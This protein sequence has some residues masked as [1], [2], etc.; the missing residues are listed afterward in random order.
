M[1]KWA[2]SNESMNE[3][4]VCEFIN[5]KLEELSSLHFL[6]SALHL[7][8]SLISQLGMFTLRKDSGS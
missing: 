7:E 1:I 8:F 2:L 3:Q 4:K 6:R 5:S